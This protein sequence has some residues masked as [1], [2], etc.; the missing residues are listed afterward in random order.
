[1]VVVALL[2]KPCDKKTSPVT[3]PT[4]LVAVTIPDVLIDTVVPIPTDFGV[5]LASVN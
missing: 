4:K 1:M 3:F 2:N 5:P